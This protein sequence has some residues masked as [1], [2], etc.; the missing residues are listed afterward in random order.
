MSSLL[1]AF[2]ASFCAS[3]SNLFFRKGN[4]VRGCASP[5]GYLFFFYFTSFVLSLFIFPEIWEIK[6]NYPILLLGA[7]VGGLS[8]LVMTLASRAMACGPAG[9]TFAFQNAS[10]IFPGLVLFLIF[11]TKGGFACSMFQVLGMALV[12]TGLFWGAG[13]LKAKAQ[14]LFYAVGCFGAQI[15]AFSLMQGRCLLFDDSEFFIKFE[16]V[17]DVWFMPGQ[18]GFASLVQLL[19]ILLGKVKIKRGEAGYGLLGGIATCGSTCLLLLSTKYALPIEK[20][21]LFPC[22]A[23]GTITLGNIWAYFLYR[24]RFQWVTTLLCSAGILLGLFI[25]LD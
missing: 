1:L 7:C 25:I 20:G 15:A 24:E 3:L 23:V 12:L 11:G 17:E 10:A 22:F 9:M 14:W 8:I 13:K 5:L 19:R 4:L 18:F 21:M 16:Q 2:I 6:V